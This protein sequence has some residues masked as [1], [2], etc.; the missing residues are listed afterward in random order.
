M[1]LD[2]LK[3][4]IRQI[5]REEIV[6][7]VEEKKISIVPPQYIAVDRTFSSNEN[8]KLE[9]GKEDEIN[10]FESDSSFLDFEK[11]DDKEVEKFKDKLESEKK[12]FQEIEEVRNEDD[13]YEEEIIEEN[14][15][16]TLEDKI[17][18]TRE[19]YRKDLDDKSEDIFD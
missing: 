17:D 11:K 15:E 19:R 7:L 13:E 4:L 5:V 12:A 18:S 10:Y 9:R 3:F 8:S 1:K 16:S 14:E 6:K 2:E